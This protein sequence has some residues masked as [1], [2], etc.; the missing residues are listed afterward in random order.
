MK[1]R[2]QGNQLIDMTEK[3]TTT[4][5]TPTGSYQILAHTKDKK[6]GTILGE[7]ATA[8]FINC[9]VFGRSAE[10]AEKYFR[11]GLKITIE[12]RIQTRSYTNRDGQKVYTTEVVVEEQEFAE[13][14]GSGSGSSQH[15]VPQQ[16]PDVGPDG[17]MNIPDGIEEELPFS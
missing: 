14:K 6:K 7:D 2:T 9:V 13:S 11:K 17:F 4:V 1:I 3:E 10:F 15:N 8:D 12:G 5:L 16:S